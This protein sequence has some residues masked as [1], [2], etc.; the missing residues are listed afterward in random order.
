MAARVEPAARVE[1]LRPLRG[2][3]VQ[4]PVALELLPVGDAVADPGARLEPPV[5]DQ[6]AGALAVA[7][8][9][10]LELAQRVKYLTGGAIVGTQLLISN[11]RPHT[12]FGQAAAIDV[13]EAGA[14]D[15]VNTLYNKL[16][17]VQDRLT[18]QDRI[19]ACVALFPK[20]RPFSY[21]DFKSSTASKL[22]DIHRKAIDSLSGWERAAAQIQYH[23]LSNEHGVYY[24]KI[25]FSTAISNKDLSAS[26]ETKR[27][28]W[29]DTTGLWI[30]HRWSI[31]TLK[32]EG[33]EGKLN[34]L[35]G[36]MQAPNCR[37]TFD[38]KIDLLSEYIKEAKNLEGGVKRGN[39]TEQ[40]CL[41]K[42]ALIDGLAGFERCK[43]YMK[44]AE[45]FSDNGIKW[46]YLF[47]TIFPEIERALSPSEQGQFQQWMEETGNAIKAE[48]EK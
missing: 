35:K 20:A 6:V 21:G 43:A 25:D 29:L 11:A 46:P 3:D 5:G 10:A 44:H 23:E 26:Q 17:A 36:L 45:F 14:E 19:R 1:Q 38:Q 2:L 16:D 42:K 34:E 8:L 32:S 39:F 4:R 13:K 27:Q 40:A 31:W 9:A 24:N 18:P 37:L 7:V 41:F 22:Q 48:W 33:L 28:E 12:F 47:K 15:K 30:A